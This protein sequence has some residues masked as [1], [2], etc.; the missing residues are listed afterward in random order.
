MMGSQAQKLRL[1]PRGFLG[2]PEEPQNLRSEKPFTSVLQLMQY[3]MADN[4]G[5]GSYLHPNPHVEALYSKA[6]K[7]TVDAGSFAFHRDV[8]HVGLA[9]FGINGYRD[10]F[11]VWFRAQY[12]NPK[13][14]D[15]HGRFLD[16]TLKFISTGKRDMSLET[17]ASLVRMADEGDSIGR[18]SDSAE[19]F[20][21]NRNSELPLIVQEWCSQPS[22]IYDFLGSLHVLY[23]NI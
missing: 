19:A 12:H 3:K 5:A 20:F 21:K 8:L 4:S 15:L 22:G 11:Q 9:A 17:W 7:Q 14:G 10:G 18:I 1:Y 6:I 23:G 2:S 13:A 16:D